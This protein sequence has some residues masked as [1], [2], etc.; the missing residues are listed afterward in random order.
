MEVL[1][2]ATSG[3]SESKLYLVSIGLQPSVPH[4]NSFTVPTL[5]NDIIARLQ[6]VDRQDVVER[7][8]E[9]VREYG[10]GSGFG[11]DHQTMS[12]DAA[13]ARSFF[14]NFVRAYDM[15]DE[16]VMVLRRSDA[17]AHQHVDPKS[18]TFNIDLP[19]RVSGDLNPVTG[20]NQAAMEI[21]RFKPGL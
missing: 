11:Y 9:R 3:R 14:V 2:S 16:N 8:L 13:F 15:T 20:L 10:S 4:D 17:L 19:A 5:V 1:E 18:L 6:S 7:F 12:R 21:L